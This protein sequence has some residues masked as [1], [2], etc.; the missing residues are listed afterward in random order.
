MLNGEC[1]IFLTHHSQDI[2]KVRLIR[3]EFERLGHNPLAFHLKCLNSD[4]EEGKKELD[5][6][7]KREID[8]RQW[9]IFCDNPYLYS[10]WVEMEKAYIIDQGKDF[11]WKIDI[12][13][14]TETILN[15]ARKICMD[16]EVFISYAHCDRK[17]IQPLKKALS[18]RDY[19]VW[20]P[21]SRINVGDNLTEQISDAIIR[22]AYKGFYIVVIS[23]ESIMSSFV[24]DELAFATSQGAWIVPVVIGNPSIPDDTRTWIGEYQQLRLNPTEND[25]NQV[26][27]ML[28][29]VLEKKI[30]NLS[31][32]SK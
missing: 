4:T 19:S 6:L 29:S 31:K 32:N 15:K 28:D 2:K 18:D 13:A 9:F 14:D 1:W 8:A 23:E 7:I 20:T 30:A 10:E 27:D 17:K 26:V 5:S 24:K 25:F 21:E 3:N 11:I 22:C 12:T 16:I